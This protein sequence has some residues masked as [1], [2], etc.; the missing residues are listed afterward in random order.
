MGWE[1]RLFYALPGHDDGGHSLR[2]LDEE[3]SVERRTDVYIAVSP[4]VGAK[5][6]GESSLEVKLCT[7]RKNRLA[8]RYEKHFPSRSSGVQA[9]QV[10][11]A[12]D[13][14][15][16]RN[17]SRVVKPSETPADEIERCARLEAGEGAAESVLFVELAKERRTSRIKGCAFEETDV[18][19]RLA[20][21][22]KDS[23]ALSDLDWKSVPTRFRSLCI[24]G[25]QAKGIYKAVGSIMS[26]Q[27]AKFVDEEHVTTEEMHDWLEALAE[28][29]PRIETDG[30]ARDGPQDEFIQG[31]FGY[32]QFVAEFASK[33]SA[34]S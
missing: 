24:E 2:I 8:E 31:I 21:V 18:K 28:S 1:W 4:S 22:N 14:F 26:D 34:R 25:G 7:G 20:V 3:R 11:E 19:V 15:L 29:R 27:K 23:G 33:Q 9:W 16:A 5:L 13:A 17:S 32:P 10:V 30:D 12:V 6:R